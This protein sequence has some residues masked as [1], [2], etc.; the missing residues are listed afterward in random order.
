M[1]PLTV[2]LRS[3]H[4]RSS[5]PSF[6]GRSALQIVRQKFPDIPFIFVSGT[7]GEEAAIES[8]LSGATDYVLKQ[9]FGRL[10]PAIQRAHREARR[11]A[12]SESRR[13]RN[14]RSERKQSEELLRASEA[15]YRRLFDG[16]P[17]P[18]WVYDEQTLQF[19]AVNDAA[20]AQYWLFPRGVSRNDRQG[21]RLFQE[22]VESRGLL[23]QWNEGTRGI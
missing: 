18:M 14:S 16:N 15:R 23:S 22:N 20:V 13:N 11:S 17:Q 10:V 19:L 2:T 6:D 21:C 7:I 9:R 5:L 4:Q 8:L 1:R 3:R 12:T